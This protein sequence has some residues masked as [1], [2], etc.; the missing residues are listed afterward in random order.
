MEFTHAN[1]LGDIT[2]ADIEAFKRW[3]KE[4]GNSEETINNALRA[5]QAIFKGCKWMAHSSVAV[6]ERH[7]AGLQAYDADIDSF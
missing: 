6:T 4:I 7:Y 2:R 5:F 1:R 3:R